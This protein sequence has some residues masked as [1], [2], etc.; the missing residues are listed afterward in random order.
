M[1]APSPF[2]QAAV[3][4]PPM[5]P[6]PISLETPTLSS[7]FPATQNQKSGPGLRVPWRWR[8]LQGSAKSLWNTS[9][10]DGDPSA[11]WDPVGL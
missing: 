3:R 10:F 8:E 6:T 11:F 2:L 1:P 7:R 9:G 4:R 5:R